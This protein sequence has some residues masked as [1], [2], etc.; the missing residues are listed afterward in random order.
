M[1]LFV[2][3]K[4][5]RNQPQ[6]FRVFSPARLTASVGLAAVAS[7]ALVSGSG[8]RLL[9]M[10]L[11]LPSRLRGFWSSLNSLS[12][13]LSPV[14]CASGHCC[15]PP[16]HT[17]GFGRPTVQLAKPSVGPVSSQSLLCRQ[18][19]EAFD[20]VIV[21]QSQIT[22]PAPLPAQTPKLFKLHL[23]PT[24]SILI[25]YIFAALAAEV[26]V[27]TGGAADAAKHAVDTVGNAAN[28]DA[29]VTA[30][31]KRLLLGKQPLRELCCCSA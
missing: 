27:S 24:D 7:G 9:G 22:N 10:R 14:D 17:N 25:S 21:D 30:G 18:A 3:E 26:G 13:L 28:V 2:L 8:R 5:V 29:T 20:R 19:R 6:L 31:P 15:S 12:S 11:P 4:L 23:P 16:A 1:L